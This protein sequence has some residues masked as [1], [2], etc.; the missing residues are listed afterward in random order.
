MQGGLV[1]Q[2]PPLYACFCSYI[3]FLEHAVL[4]QTP[5]VVPETEVISPTPPRLLKN[6]CRLSGP[7]GWTLGMCSFS[8][9]TFLTPSMLCWFFLPL[10]AHIIWTHIAAHHCAPPLSSWPSYPAAVT[11]MIMGHQSSY[12]ALWRVVGQDE[13]QITQVPRWPEETHSWRVSVAGGK[14]LYILP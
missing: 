9:C 12:R 5:A 11:M 13:G 14:I 7:A 8:F 6:I 3:V 10:E 1:L 4:L 2:G